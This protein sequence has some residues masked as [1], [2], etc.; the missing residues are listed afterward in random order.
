MWGQLPWMQLVICPD[1]HIVA[2]KYRAARQAAQRVEPIVEDVVLQWFSTPGLG[3]GER[4][5]GTKI[6]S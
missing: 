1:G 3:A 4:G 2:A 5:V 6:S